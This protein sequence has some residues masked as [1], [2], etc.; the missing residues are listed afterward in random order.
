MLKLLMEVWCFWQ[1]SFQDALMNLSFHITNYEN[2]A[3]SSGAD[4]LK[5]VLFLVGAAWPAAP[6]L[7]IEFVQKIEDTE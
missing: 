6:R 4:L 3:R 7:E 1:I 5:L 2:S